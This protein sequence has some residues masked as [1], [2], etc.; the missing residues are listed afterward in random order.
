[1]GADIHVVFACEVGVLRGEGDRIG[2]TT[3]SR[4]IIVGNSG[5]NGWLGGG[6]HLFCSSEEIKVVVRTQEGFLGTYIHEFF[7]C[8]VGI[9]QGA[10]ECNGAATDGEG[11]I[12][13]LS[14]FCV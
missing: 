8:E 2:G 5:F 9:L 14:Y 11:S 4:G 1:M 10:V 13:E 6:G 12:S 3:R 7:V